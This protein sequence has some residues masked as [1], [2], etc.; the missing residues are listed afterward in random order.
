MDKQSQTRIWQIL[1]VYVL[2]WTLA[3]SISSPNLDG[4]GDM[5]ESFAWGQTFDWGSFKHPP[6]IGWIAGLWFRVLPPSDPMFFMLS[7]GATALG[8]LGIFRLA[9][10]LGLGRLSVAAVVVQM[11]ALPYSTLAAKFNANSIL[12]TLWPWVAYFWWTCISERRVG[13]FHPLML[14]LTAAIAMLGKYYSGVL[15]LS[16]G[17]LTLVLPAGRRWLGSWQP[18]F[19]LA[20]MAAA[21]L[22]HLTWLAHH[23]YVTLHYVREQGSGSVSWTNLLKFLLSP[24]MYWGIALGICVAAFRGQGTRW[25]QR[26]WLAWKPSGA[27][28]A[29]FWLALLPYGL[30][31]LF[32]LSGFVELS[33]PWSIPVGFA[34]PLLWL[35]NLAATDLGRVSSPERDYWSEPVRR[36]FYA[37]PVIVIIG[38]CAKTALDIRRGDELSSLPRREAAAA[39][40]AEWRSLSPT[41]PPAWVGGEWAEN[42]TLAFYGDPK[43]RVIP[44]LPG[45]FPVTLDARDDWLRLPGLIYCPPVVKNPSAQSGCETAA[46]GWLAAHDLPIRQI[47]VD[48]SRAGWRFGQARRF[49]YSAFV[50]L[51]SGD[52]K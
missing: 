31:L 48:A 26:L 19:A 36:I 11:Y 41:T 42:A 15:L 10:A 12:L 16:L 32:G 40:L 3:Q 23:D 28:D 20:V 50:V 4:Y 21:L 33:L 8:L 6:L 17:L 25:W 5:L 13:L 34:F 27:G 35:R 37:L 24:L 49:H 14:G 38:A 9:Q 1:S 46:R 45:E 39:V 2:T 52:G 7:F 18:W 29:L 47:E 44:G 30:T 51:P 43:I 22:P